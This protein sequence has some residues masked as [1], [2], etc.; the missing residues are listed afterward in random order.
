MSKITPGRWKVQ[1]GGSGF[2]GGIFVDLK[3][4]GS[5]AVLS[6]VQRVPIK[7]SDADKALIQAAP[8]LLE[9]AEAMLDDLSLGM[10]YGGKG[11]RMLEAAIA[12][13]EGGEE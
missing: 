5:A 1:R 9:A 7:I 6:T 3:P 4:Y 8:D 11:E 13:A 2:S 10:P 12:K